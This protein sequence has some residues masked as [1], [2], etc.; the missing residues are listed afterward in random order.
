MHGFSECATC[1]SSVGA[2]FVV[3]RFT[4]HVRRQQGDDKGRPYGAQGSESQAG[5]K[6]GHD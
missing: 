4:R 5:Y 6:T 1:L 2:T 3:A